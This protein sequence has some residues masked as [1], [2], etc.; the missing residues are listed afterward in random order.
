MGEHVKLETERFRD[1]WLW[2]EREDDGTRSN[3]TVADAG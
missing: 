2:R 3:E 1:G